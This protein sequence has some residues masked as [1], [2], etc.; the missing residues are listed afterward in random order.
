MGFFDKLFGAITSP[1]AAIG[2]AV[3]GA[4]G[5][6]DSNKKNVQLGREQMAFQERMSSTAYQRAI[7]DMQAAGLN[8][9]AGV[10]AGRRECAGWFYATSA[11]RR[12]GR[13]EFGGVGD[14]HDAVDAASCA[15]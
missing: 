12:G 15:E 2:S 11:E 13:C 4:L 9:G 8:P 14:W 1:V 3:I 7:A 5:Q 6:S 10:F